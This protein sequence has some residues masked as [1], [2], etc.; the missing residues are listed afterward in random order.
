MNYPVF[1]DPIFRDLNA[2][3]GPLHGNFSIAINRLL[4]DEYTLESALYYFMLRAKQAARF[5]KEYM[6]IS[7]N[8]LDNKEI[9]D[10]VMEKIGDGSYVKD[11][12]YESWE[13]APEEAR[14]FATVPLYDHPIYYYFK[15]IASTDRIVEALKNKVGSFKLLQPV[16]KSHEA[17]ALPLPIGWRR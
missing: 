4:E 5:L 15:N 9:V 3:L 13:E 10:K 16:N 6:G 8:S 7:M 14:R 1:Q 11:S 17:S 12:G 2:V